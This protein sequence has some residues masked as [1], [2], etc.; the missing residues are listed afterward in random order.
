MLRRIGIG[1]VL[2]AALAM[3]AGA[4]AELAPSDFKNA[5]KYCKA[6]RAELGVD[7]FRAQF[8][9]NKGKRNAFGKCVA[10]HARGEHRAA[11][12]AL[13][14][15]KAEYATDPAAFMTKYGAQ[16]VAQSLLGRPGERGQGEDTDETRPAK[17]GADV[18]RAI[19][20][21]VK[22]KLQKVTTDRREAL[23]NAVEQCKEERGETEELRAAF[24]NKYG[25]NENKRNALGKCVSQKVRDGGSPPGS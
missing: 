16:P 12:L 22:L 7:A 24:R 11:K 13:R 20:R 3:P 9:S 4:S 25:T 18:R 14:E 6:L 21:C 23:E 5:A 2:V 10:K 17:P 8:G 15:C 1:C 19:K